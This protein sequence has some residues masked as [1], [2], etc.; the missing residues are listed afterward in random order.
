MRHVTIGAIALGA[1]VSGLAFGQIG[2]TT[3]GD[4][5]VKQ[6]LDDIGYKYKLTKAHDFE[7]IFDVGKGRSQRVIVESGTNQYGTFEVRVI[8]STGYHSETRLTERQLRILLEDS[9]ARKLGAWCVLSGD[10]GDLAIFTVKAAA[11][12]S[13]EDMRALIVLVTEVADE[14][15]ER[16]TGADDL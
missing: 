5:R 13:D 9:A 8:G 16:L 14:M 1:V 12:L 2:G 4:K 11:E 15:E 10:E 7:L 6:V 3:S